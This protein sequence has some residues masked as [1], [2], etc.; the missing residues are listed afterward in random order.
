[1]ARKQGQ[2]WLAQEC[3]VSQPRIAQ[4]VADGRI[5]R[6]VSYGEA[7]VRRAKR[8]L[9]EGRAAN[10][11]TAAQDED[12]GDETAIERLS[13]NPERVA[14][15]K[16]VIE[17]TAKIKLERELLAGGY[18]KRE[19]VERERVARIYAVRAKM[20]EMPLRSSLLVGKTD[21]EIHQSLTAWMKEI[22]D[23]F[24]AGGS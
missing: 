12:A 22:C 20:Q 7:D 3:G 24:A 23:H 14:R 10:N 19:D 11:A 5:P 8:A 1:M 15:I 16:L 21:A 9:L 6:K 2:S 4:L 13:K 18:L 17:R